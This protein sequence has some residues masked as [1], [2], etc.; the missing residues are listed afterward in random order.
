[1]EGMIE[2]GLSRLGG[3]N[4]F[5]KI[6]SIRVLFLQSLESFKSLKSVVLFSA[7]CVLC[8]FAVNLF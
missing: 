1:M 2:R 7:L 5:R 3:C 6:C 4:G 8:A